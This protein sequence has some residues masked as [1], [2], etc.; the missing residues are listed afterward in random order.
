MVVHD[1]D[2]EYGQ[3]VTFGRVEYDELYHALG[4]GFSEAGC[5]LTDRPMFEIEQ[6]N[7]SRKKYKKDRAHDGCFVCGF[8]KYVELA[9]IKPRS[10]GGALR[11]PLC[12]N[13]HKAFDEGFMTK[14]EIE[15]LVE[16]VSERM[17]KNAA[18]E[19][20]RN[21]GAVARLRYT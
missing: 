13:H 14:R 21:H 15:S 18:V 9:H 2:C 3:S 11:I 20:S 4:D 10:V 12:P 6:A 5:C 8:S 1:E 16:S 19:I 17:G 7:V